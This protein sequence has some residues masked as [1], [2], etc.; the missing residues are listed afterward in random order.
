LKDDPPAS[1]LHA[2]LPLGDREKE[3]RVLEI[4]NCLLDRLDRVESRVA[5]LEIS[6]HLIVR[7]SS[8]H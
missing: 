6:R 7:K 8:V 4:F 5:R 3:A 2:K 1:I